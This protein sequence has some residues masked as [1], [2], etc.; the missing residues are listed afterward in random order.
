MEN[1]IQDEVT[2]PS[3]DVK[4]ILRKYQE[5]EDEP[6]VKIVWTQAECRAEA[7]DKNRLGSYEAQGFWLLMASHCKE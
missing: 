5:A 4:E 6:T 7:D 1:L 2:Q 3:I